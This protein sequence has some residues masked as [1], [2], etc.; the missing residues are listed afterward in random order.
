[1]VPKIIIRVAPL[2]VISL[3]TLNPG[4]GQMPE[5]SGEPGYSS[6]VTDVSA[7]EIGRSI[8][9]ESLQHPY[10]YFSN[11]D[12]EAIL[13][14][15]RNDYE[16]RLIMEGLLAEAFKLLHQPVV[17]EI[18][19]QGLNPRAG[20]AP[21]D[22]DGNTLTG[23]DRHLRTNRDNAFKL[24]FVYQMTGD[25]KYAVKAFEFA[26][27]FC[28]LPSW[29]G[30]A[31]EFPIIYPRIWPWNVSDD[32]VNFSFDHYNGDSG[33]IMAAVYDWLYPALDK[34]GR[35]R[36]RGALLE[37]VITR[38]R[39]HYEQH[40]W[41]TAYRC[42]WCGVNNS[43]LGLTALALLKE[44]PEFIDVVSESY[45]RINK[46]LSELGV[47]GAWQEGGGYWNYGVHTSAFFAD[48][49]KR[50]TDSK[51][52]LFSNE[53]LSNNP[54]TFPLYISLPGGGSLNFEDSRGGTIGSAHLFSKLAAETGSREAVWY[55][56]EKF[57][58]GNNIFDLIWPLPDIEPALPENPSIH[59][60]TWDWWVMRSDFTDP[61]K[62]LVAGK[63]GRNNDPHHGHLDVGH[64]VV[65]WEGEYYINDIGMPRYDQI[66]FN[67]ERWDHYPHATSAGHNVVIVNG[68]QQLPGKRKNS[69]W[70]HDIG[71]RVVEFRTAGNSDYVLMD[72]SDAYKGVELKGW[73]RHVI[74]EK[75]EITLVLDEIISKPGA[76]IELRFHSGVRSEIKD[77][78]V[79]LTGEAGKMVLIP[80][81]GENFMF[82]PG[83][84]AVQVVHMEMP[85]TWEPYFGTVLNSK[86]EKTEIAT[87]IL[88]VV[89]ESQAYS[90]AN[91]IVRETDDSGNLSVSFTK[92]GYTHSYL[93]RRDAQG[94]LLLN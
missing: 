83:M 52:N 24:A 3:I 8:A 78:L 79:M 67:D 25:E 19:V 54:V 40:W 43:G 12:K 60:R 46:M 11:S 44:H 2:W 77:K 59:F 39:G 47:D 22:R 55:R 74:L 81:T 53:R 42:N 49:L 28:E 26:D 30:R 45:N 36:L 17:Y 87:L 35:D 63:A 31:H 70:N 41:A 51:Y 10:L 14:R 58:R 20:W 18:P 16:S 94:Y 4:Y 21:E 6:T 57:S 62:V 75:P 72:A 65:H 50:L 9:L 90:V 88:P 38:V 68:E 15:I 71:G 32:Q 64:F 33:R 37:K 86:S 56:Q 92:D 73:R 1:M 5:W 66:Y 89:D 7:H 82:R 85:L 29:T 23:Y 48:A 34:A 80:V 27:A 61:S 84:H 91:S 13:E 69:D 76:E 93:F